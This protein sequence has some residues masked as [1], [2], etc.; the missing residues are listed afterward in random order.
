MIKAICE[1][2]E[3]KKAQEIRLIK[4]AEGR[5]KHA[6]SRMPASTSGNQ[7]GSQNPEGQMED[8]LVNES[9]L[10]T[11]REEENLGGA[12]LG[13]QVGDGDEDSEA[14]D[15]AG[16]S[17]LATEGPSEEDVKPILKKL[18]SSRKRKSKTS[19]GE[20]RK[21]SSSESSDDGVV[22]PGRKEKGGLFGDLIE[23]N[24]SNPIFNSGLH[25]RESPLYVCQL[26]S[27]KVKVTRG[28]A[29][30]HQTQRSLTARLADAVES[31][32]LESVRN[33]R[34]ELDVAQS[35][36]EK[37]RDLLGKSSKSEE[38]QSRKGKKKMKKSEKGKKKKSNRKRKRSSS[39]SGDGSS[40]GDSGRQ[41]DVPA[42][43]SKESDLSSDS[44]S[45]S[46]YLA[47]SHVHSD[48]AVEH[49]GPRGGKQQKKQ[50]GGNRGHNSGYQKSYQA[51]NQTASQFQRRDRNSGKDWV[52]LGQQHASNVA[53]GSGTV[54]GP[55][56]GGKKGIMTL[57][58]NER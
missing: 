36:L 57:G 39:P 41:V 33:L 25:V 48:D 38:G 15:S 4:Q 7:I 9:N 55:A 2:E 20:E 56:K 22:I 45:D 5:R 14:S 47:K 35:E 11:V 28:G 29:N 58:A 52:A 12:A 17:G 31:E 8:R 49:E 13:E 50:C 21:V 6:E 34:R 18:K 24:Q 42:K 23:K 10:T 40:S 19:R 30:K 44:E 16:S 51:A 54:S 1:A 27:S 37:A 26:S 32:N 43:S 53:S 3:R 46:E